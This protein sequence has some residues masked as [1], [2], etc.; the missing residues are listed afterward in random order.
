MLKPGGQ[1]FFHTLDKTFLEEAYDVL[2]QGKWSKY[3]NRKSHSPF[4]SS[5]DPLNDYQILIRNLGYVDCHISS[6]HF[7]A[8]LPKESFEGNSNF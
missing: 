7:K 5:E 8:N 4:Y 6:E 2:D 3:N 1:L